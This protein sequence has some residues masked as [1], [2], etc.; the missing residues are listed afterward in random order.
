[1]DD[2]DD[3]DDD[4]KQWWLDDTFNG[5]TYQLTQSLLDLF[6]R[7][8]LPLLTRILDALTTIIDYFLHTAE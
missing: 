1:M 8:L 7:P 5:A 4:E 6:V 2:M 3:M